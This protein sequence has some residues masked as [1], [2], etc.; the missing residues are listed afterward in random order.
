MP[1]Q[2]EPSRKRQPTKWNSSKRVP[3]RKVESVKRP[4]IAPS[5]M[6]TKKSSGVEEKKRNYDKPWN[7]G[8][9]GTKGNSSSK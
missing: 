5:S 3:Q 4:P 2:Y 6:G 8:S 7:S 1:P 9:K